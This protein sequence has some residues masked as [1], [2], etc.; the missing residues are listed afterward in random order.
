[1]KTTMACVLFS[2]IFLQGCKPAPSEFPVRWTKY[3]E[4]KS[5][6][7]IDAQMDKRLGPFGFQDGLRLGFDSDGVTVHTV[8]EYLAGREK[9]YETM[10][11]SEVKLEGDF[12]RAAVP[13]KYL[14]NAIPARVSYVHDLKL[15]RRPLDLPA[16]IGPGQQ[17]EISP[18]VKQMMAKGKTWREIWPDKTWNIYDDYCIDLEDEDG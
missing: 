1:M 6:D 14:K 7:D 11:G 15:S 5:L 17:H 4:L 9:G 16:T 10:Y 12:K 2:I 3:V 13:A 8:R 18:H